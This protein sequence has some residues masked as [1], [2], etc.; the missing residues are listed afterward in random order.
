M[1]KMASSVSPV[2]MPGGHAAVLTPQTLLV[3]ATCSL[4]YFALRSLYNIYIYPFYVSPLRHIPSPLVRPTYAVDPPRPNV[5]SR[6][7]ST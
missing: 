6:S 3:L 7:L 4:V 5:N 2:A 1:D